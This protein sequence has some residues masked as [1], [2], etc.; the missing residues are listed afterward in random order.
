[1][2]FDMNIQSESGTICITARRA[3]KS[4]MIIFC[5]DEYWAIIVIDQVFPSANDKTEGIPSEHVTTSIY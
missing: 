5:F 4:Q 2:K 3:V 1:M